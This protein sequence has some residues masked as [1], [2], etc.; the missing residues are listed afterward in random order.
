VEIKIDGVGSDSSFGAGLQGHAP[1]RPAVHV[2]SEDEAFS[3]IAYKYNVDP[4]NFA[5]INGIK[6][7]YKVKS[8]QILKLP[9]ENE[10]LSNVSTVASVDLGNEIQSFEEDEKNN[11]KKKDKLDAELEEIL[12]MPEKKTGTSE[13]AVG[14]NKSSSKAAKNK[15]L[16]EQDRLSRPAVVESA[17]GVPIKKTITA[18]NPPVASASTKS[19]KMQWPV[20]GNV[21]T[22]FG[23]IKDGAANDGINIKAAMGTKVLAASDGSVIY[24]GKNLEEDYGNVVIVQHG[25]GLITSYAHLDSIA[26]KN[27][28]NVHAG[29]MVGT[30]GKTGD[31]TEPQL[32]FEVMK[33]KK[34]VDPMKY[35]N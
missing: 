29:E 4:V 12:G 31:V 14:E 7:P 2:V 16:A 13:S 3:D 10:P 22:H 8:G 1:S 28:A 27:G 32:Y 20:K 11:G 24:V 26:V 19:A 18:K 6:P 23:D 9:S 30:V 33:D 21:V 5:K 34:P 35:L 25:N 17:V 15:Q